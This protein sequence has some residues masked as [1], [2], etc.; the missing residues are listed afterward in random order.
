[1]IEF[2]IYYVSVSITCVFVFKCKN[3][4]CLKKIKHVKDID[5][6]IEPVLAESLIDEKVDYKNLIM[7][8]ILIM[9]KKGSIK[10]DENSNLIYVNYDNLSRFEYKIANIIF[11]S[12]EN[13]KISFEEINN[14]FWNNNKTSRRMY[15]EF[16]ELKEDI[17][18]FFYAKKLYSKAC[19][20]IMLVIKKLSFWVILFSMIVSIYYLD[21]IL[22]GNYN[23][24]YVMFFAGII[25]AFIILN[26]IQLI[27][28]IEGRFKIH[29]DKVYKN[30]LEKVE[31]I[32]LIIYMIKLILIF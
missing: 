30:N 12:A 23:F 18:R 21:M 15:K 31:M 25:V 24:I 5:D 16:I 17:V 10:I 28:R 6:L 20:S 8:A 11:K 26:L 14:I 3:R 13:N 22:R 32:I 29:N 7:S 9:I 2:L 19:D 27:T 1:M 4:G